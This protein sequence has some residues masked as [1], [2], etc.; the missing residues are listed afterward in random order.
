MGA[1][2]GI[3]FEAGGDSSNQRALPPAQTCASKT[4]C[5]ARISRRKVIHGIVNPHLGRGDPTNPFAKG[6]SQVSTLPLISRPA[7]AHRVLEGTR[8]GLSDWR[9]VGRL[10]GVTCP[11]LLRTCQKRADTLQAKGHSILLQEPSPHTS[12]CTRSRQ[13]RSGRGGSVLPRVDLHVGL[14]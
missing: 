11:R 2:G 14:T 4:S 3:A 8:A 7:A 6:H 12:E 13:F 9:A 5:A 10:W 1:V